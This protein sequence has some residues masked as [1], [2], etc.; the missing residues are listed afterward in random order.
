MPSTVDKASNK[1]KTLILSNQFQNIMLAYIM[2][3]FMQDTV[4]VTVIMK[5]KFP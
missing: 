1:A 5:I 3:L 2:N 4:P